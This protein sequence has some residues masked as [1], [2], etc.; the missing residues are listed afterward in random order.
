MYDTHGV[1]VNTLFD[2]EA[3]ANK[4]YG[5]KVNTSQMNEGVY[6][7]RLGTLQQVEHQKVV[8]IR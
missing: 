2:G 6:I 1:V 8:L 7:S 5:L 3:E 4:R